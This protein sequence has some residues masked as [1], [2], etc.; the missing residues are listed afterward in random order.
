VATENL[1]RIYKLT[2]EGSQAE[3]QLR[4]IA[5]STAGVDKQIN[6]FSKSL[7]SLQ[8]NLLAGLTFGAVVAGFKSI[9]DSMSEIVDTSAKLGVA[10]D[11]LQKLRFAASQ[12]GVNAGALETGIKKLS[13][14]LTE[15]DDKSSEAGAQLRALGVTSKD[16]VGTAMEKIADEFQRA[17]DGAGKTAVAIKAFGKSGNELV[18][19]LNEGAD[20]LRR[21]G[22][23]AE[24]LGLIVSGRDLQL[25]DQFGDNMDRLQRVLGSVGIQIAGGVVPALTALTDSLLN[26][27]KSGDAFKNLGT[28]IGDAVVFLASRF[29]ELWAAVKQFAS[30]LGAAAGALVAFFSGDF[31]E[32]GT[33]LVEWVNDTNK[34]G[35]EASAAVKRLQESYQNYVANGVEPTIAKQTELATSTKKVKEAFTEVSAALMILEEDLRVASEAAKAT[36]DFNAKMAKQKQ[37]E[38]QAELDTLKQIEEGRLEEL[39]IASEAAEATAKFYEKQRKAAQDLITPVS[40]LNDN[41]EAFFRNLE[42]GT[43]DAEEAFKRMVQSMI[44]QMLKLAAQWLVLKAFGIDLGWGTKSGAAADGFQA[45][46][47]AQASAPAFGPRSLGATPVTVDA[48]QASL[49]PLARTAPQQQQGGK[50]TEVHVHNNNGSAVEVQTSEDGRRIDVLIERTRRALAADLRAGGNVFAS[51]VESTY[52]LGRARG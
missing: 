13:V 41:F 34:A 2:V 35:E 46:A 51:A 21:F 10:T 50:G 30:G 24:R 49:A 9:V 40:I 5:G 14:G 27:A 16:T 52:A 26:A 28:A 37:D 23:E 25:F 39:R 29:I 32:A 4:E 17:G 11:E 31:R 36:A 3:R 42:N 19:M 18:P 44:A 33:I 47:T 1:E 38:L 12:L 20:G 43:A 22:D 8:R 45:V 15:I 6:E 48:S 7:Q